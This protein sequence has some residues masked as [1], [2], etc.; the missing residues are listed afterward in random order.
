MNAQKQFILRRAKAHF[1]ASEFSTFLRCQEKEILGKQGFLGGACWAPYRTDLWI[2]FNHVIAFSEKAT[3]CQSTA[4]DL[5][6]K[7]DNDAAQTPKDGFK[8]TSYTLATLR[9]G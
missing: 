2:H 6:L 7:S 1:W 9:F 5:G 4:N 3:F 8:G